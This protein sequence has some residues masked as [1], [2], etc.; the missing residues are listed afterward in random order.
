MTPRNQTYIVAVSIA[1][2]FG[3]W[4]LIMTNSGGPIAFVSSPLSAAASS[5][6][7]QGAAKMHLD[8]AM[9]ALQA[10]D[11]EGAKMHL[12]EADKVLSEGAAKMHLDE[13]M[14]A[15]QAGDTEGAKMHAQAAQ[16][17]L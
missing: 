11:T 14:K 9:K 1:V 2:L 4:T 7:D 16:D 5:I 13:A 12:S 8:E 10:G 15:L 6:G 3:V 17:S